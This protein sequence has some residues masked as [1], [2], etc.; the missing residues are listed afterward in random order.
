MYLKIFKVIFWTWKKYFLFV[1]LSVFFSL[2][3]YILSNNIILSVETYI[4]SQ[5]KPIFWWD[6]VISGRYEIDKN[7]NFEKY[8]ST[9]DIAKTISTNSTIF[10]ENKNPKLVNLVYKTDNY[11][12]YN[13]FTYKTINNSW[14]LIVDNKT[15]ETFW[16]NIEILGQK[17][18][19]KWIINSTSIWDVSMFS[20]A[21]D[22]YLPIEFFPEN[23][24]STNSRISYEYFLK[25]KQNYDK[26]YVNIL[27]K[28]NS[29]SEYRIRSLDD[30]N[31]NIWD[32]TDRFYLFINFFNLVI[33]NLAFF[34]IILSLEIFFKKIKSNIAL[35]NIFW[36]SKLSILKYNIIA[37]SIIFL[38][39]I[40]LAY[41]W[42]ILFLSFLKTKFEFFELYFIS[43]QKWFFV[44]L[45]LLVVWVFSPFYKIYKSNIDVL[46][47]D[48]SSFSAFK[49]YDYILYLS[50][51]FLWFLLINFISWI[52]IFY[53][54]LFSFL[55][56][57]FL[58]LSYFFTDYLIKYLFLKI[59]KFKIN[60]Y[61]FD[62][63]RATTKPWNVS[64]LIIFSWVISFISIFV[65]YVFSGSF[66]TYLQTITV[67]S[68]DSFI[69]NV[70]QKDLW[71]I[72][73]YFSEDEIFE[74]VALKIKFINWK[75]LSEYLNTQKVSREFSR[76]FF[77]TT[78][79]LTNK[80]IS[81]EKL[82]LW[83]VSVDTEFAK[84]L[85]LKIWD[86]ITF[87]VAWLE[88]S[89]KVDNFR[90]AKRN[91]TDPFFYFMLDKWDFEKYPKNYIISYKSDAKII[92]I[93]NT[94]SKEVWPYLSFISVKEIIKTVS[95]IATQI[96]TVVYF[97]LAYI[98]LFSI[99]CFFVSISFLKTFKDYKLKLLNILW[100]NY[101][102]LVFYF[103]IEYI[104]LI[105]IWLVFSI[106]V[107]SLI[108]VSVFYFIKY[109]SFYY[110]IYFSWIF[111]IFA[112]FLFMIILMK[113]FKRK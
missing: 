45:V 50:L 69:I 110:S 111:I 62:S 49:I 34:I 41:L 101:K 24:N 37:I 11:P 105:F 19:V 68:R 27:K 33:F 56:L 3:S 26:N 44:A 1:F 82:K 17:Y 43:V 84:R 21:T 97:C 87:S 58:V 5:I 79:I 83:W 85:D 52:N 107:W 100:W 95:E 112:I 94:L 20:S 61:L 14:A 6:I 32:I 90:E 60:F 80:I 46:L 64:F 48:N 57:V 103:D 89:L 35:L 47:K 23:L 22:I 63:L 9:F 66:L 18:A 78:N 29:L 76:E 28:D 74:I 104:Y 73:K 42:N 16:E 51:I 10:D 86:K 91:W 71:V 88:K 75:T 38:L 31:E 98:F 53:S 59:S 93:E 108:I 40:F 39:S 13:S 113:I 102:K 67:S 72:K 4:K 2:F 30:R 55:F 70:Q 15:F 109:F 54:F 12:F 65:F 8:N 92:N 25:F 96:L 77:S 106:F 81:W 36:M 99:I 7:V